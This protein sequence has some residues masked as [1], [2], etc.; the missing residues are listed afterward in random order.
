MGW[1][2]EVAAAVGAS[3]YVDF[4][5]FWH[6]VA[7]ARLHLL[8]RERGAWIG[9]T[10]GRTSYGTAPRP[11]TAAGAGAWLRLTEFTVQLFVFND[12]AAAEIYTD[13]QSSA[14]A[15]PGPVVLEGILGAR[16]WSRG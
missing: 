4:A 10:A 8:G 2:G 15:E 13:L 1:R 12:P 9:G 7:A 5:S 16:M 3:R 14:R 6:A 11:V